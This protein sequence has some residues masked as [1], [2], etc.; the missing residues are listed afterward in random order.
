MKPLALRGYPTADTDPVIPLQCRGLPRNRNAPNLLLPAGPT[1]VRLCH[2][3]TREQQNLKEQS[4]GVFDSG[5]GGLTVV[6]EIHRVLPGEDIIYVGDTARAPYGIRP[7]ETIRRFAQ[8]ITDFLLRYSPKMI[9]IACNTASAAAGELLEKSCPVDLVDAIRPG[10]SAALERTAG[11]VG[12]IATETTVRSGAY[13]RAVH[14]IDPNRRVISAAC[15]LLVPI[16]EEGRSPDD[17]VVVAVLSDY[18][19]RLQRDLKP[20][21]SFKAVP[22]VDG[23]PPAALVLGCTHYPLLEGAIAKVMGPHVGL[24]SSAK[25]AAKEAQRKLYL[26]GIHSDR[27]SGGGLRCFTTADP[28]RFTRLGERF[29]G[30]QLDSVEHIELDELEKPAA[31]TSDRRQD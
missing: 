5:L 22:C 30:R 13:E 3:D 25:A 26:K 27:C 18:L 19:H 28:Q 31:A 10:A 2:V 8:Q 7:L 1:C 12:V 15:P 14:A 9:V 4:I 11:P 24:V 29:G 23:K 21:N 16:I 17:A 6:R 20:A